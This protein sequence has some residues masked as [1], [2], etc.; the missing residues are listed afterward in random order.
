MLHGG[1]SV[2]VAQS[3]AMDLALALAGLALAGSAAATAGAAAVGLGDGGLGGSQ[4]CG[5]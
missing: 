1:H 5:L 4:H 2:Q 3:G